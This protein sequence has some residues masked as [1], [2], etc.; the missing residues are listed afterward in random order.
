[1]KNLALF[2][3]DGTITSV[4]T[5]FDFLRY[6]FGDGRVTKEIFI[7]LP[8]MVAGLTGITTRAAAKE[9][10][11]S[12]FLGGVSVNLFSQYCQ[13]YCD[14]RLPDVLRYQALKRIEWHQAS[15]DDV[16]IVS[17]SPEDWIKPWAEQRDIEVLATQLATCGEL[18]TGTFRSA[19]CNGQEKVTRI[20]EAI[21]LGNY[22]KIFAYGDSSGDSGMFGISDASYFRKFK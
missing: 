4:D 15:G 20:R 9:V 2:D 13:R 8:W 6:C 16:Y 10:F 17:A 5:L 21:E 3:F 22:G 18:L 1:M 14:R 7:C 11:L 12:R 19:N